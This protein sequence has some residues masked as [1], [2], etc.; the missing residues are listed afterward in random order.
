MK[1]I[2]LILLTAIVL[3][4]CSTLKVMSDVDRSIDF[5]QYKTLEFFGWTDTSTGIGG[6]FAKNRI[7]NSFRDE[8]L[9]RG[10]KTVNK[11]EGDMI[12]SL[13]IVSEKKT[14]TFANTNTTYIG[15]PYGRYGYGG[16]YGY[17]PRYGWGGGYV[18]SSTTYTKRENNEGTLIISAYDAKKEELV[19]EAIAVKTIDRNSRTPEDDIAKAVAKIMTTYPIQTAK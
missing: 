8:F 18:H 5:S 16:Y 7:E 10:I 1:N 2:I 3:S 14:E 17:G 19:W 15:G 13:F 12:I 9:K 11:G 6:S 4:S